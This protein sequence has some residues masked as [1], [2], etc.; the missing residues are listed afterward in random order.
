MLGTLEGGHIKTIHGFTVPE[1]LRLQ[2][3]LLSIL[4]TK[5]YNDKVA[6]RVI[7]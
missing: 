2:C 3:I 4:S 6:R 5:A 1:G 7:L